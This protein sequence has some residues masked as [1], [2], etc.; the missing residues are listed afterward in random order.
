MKSSSTTRGERELFRREGA[1][2]YLIVEG[3]GESVMMQKGEFVLLLVKHACSPLAAVV[4]MV[5]DMQWPVGKDSLVL[6]GKEN[7]YSFS[8]PASL[9]FALAFI[10]PAAPDRLHHL[11]RLDCLLHQYSTFMQQA[12]KFSSQR[13]RL[14][15]S[16]F[17]HCLAALASI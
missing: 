2:L 15:R 5:G 14:S 6:K 4:A 3:E 8:L 13:A 16:I 7:R 1:E 11:Q 10:P 12:G 17:M 9:T